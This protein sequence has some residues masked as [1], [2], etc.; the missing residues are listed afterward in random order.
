MST[1]S[2]TDLLTAYSDPT[3]SGEHLSVP[4]VVESFDYDIPT[5]DLYAVGDSMLDANGLVGHHLRSANNF[6]QNGIREIVTNGFDIEKNIVNRRAAT[7]EDKSIERIHCEVQFNEVTIFPP[8]TLNYITGQEVMLMPQA[9][10]L[11]DKTYSGVLQLG[12]TIKATAYLKG[13]G[14][15]ERTD[16]VSNFRA[17]RVP[18]IKGSVLCNTYGKSKEALAQMN[19]DP[20]DPGGYFIVKSE[21]A[22]D[23]TESTTFNQEK[24]Y[25][26][27]GYGKSRVRFDYISKPGD[28]YQNSEMCILIFNT[29]DTF[30]VELSRDKLMGVKIPFYLLF[31]AMG[32]STDKE[33]LDWIVFDYDADSHKTLLKHCID[34]MAAKYSKTE[35]RGMFD[36][37]DCLRA[38][39]DLIPEESFKYLEL[40]KVPENYSL[41]INDVLNTFDA[42]FLPH[43]GLT[44]EYRHSK[45]KFLAL[46]IR[47]V[48]L[49]YL[50]HIPQTDRDSYRI[51]R[52][53][54]AGDNYAK[55][56]KTLFN[57]TVAM[58][59]KKYMNKM[60]NS[61]PFSQVNLANLVKQ[62]IYV[63]DF[64][65]LIVQTIVSGNKSSLKIKRR[66]VTN[67]NSSIERI[68]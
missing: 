38:I 33:M 59:I 28:T 64:E 60:F 4:L 19:E 52:I 30:T 58:P 21:W 57:Q 35:Y 20:T 66:T 12:C 68:S 65:R 34:A 11:R 14:T 53:H 50:R 44:S 39:V 24:I 10:L 32:W 3:F 62:S 16:T 67:R 18:I 47:K 29:D 45:L 6:Y 46:L 26:N 42:H 7:P 9:A 43:I 49:T 55:T 48:L 13:G 22:V 40:K 51:K 5:D 1:N 63:D 17:A 27:E 41:A 54:A 2:T 36:Q 15:L 56:F 8:T 37:N 31:R 61:T 23:C 25:I